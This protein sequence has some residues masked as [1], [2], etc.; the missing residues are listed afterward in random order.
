MKVTNGEKDINVSESQEGN[1]H[2]RVTRY[3]EGCTPHLRLVRR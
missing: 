2:K 1:K 3:A